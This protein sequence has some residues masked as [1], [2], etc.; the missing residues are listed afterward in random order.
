MT[1]GLVAVAAVLSELMMAWRS[2]P[3]P[4]SASLLT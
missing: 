1:L 3:D 4:L 2:V